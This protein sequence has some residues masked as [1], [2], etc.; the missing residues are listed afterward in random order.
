MIF[1]VFFFFLNIKNSSYKNENIETKYLN[2]MRNSQ[3]LKV[4]NSL[5]GLEK[6]FIRLKDR[7]IKDRDLRIKREIEKLF[8]KPMIVSIDDLDK[9]E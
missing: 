2:N 4:R 7:E 6:D 3:F 9:F 8:F 5:F 1:F